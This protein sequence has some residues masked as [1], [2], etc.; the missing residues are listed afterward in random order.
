MCGAVCFAEFFVKH[1]RL[2]RPKACRVAR[3][4]YQGENYENDENLDKN[5]RIQNHYVLMKS[6]FGRSFTR[7]SPCASRD[8]DESSN[9]RHIT[10]TMP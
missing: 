6:P 4:A 7:N 1:T 9:E 2:L 8:Q 10:S 3:L 5:G